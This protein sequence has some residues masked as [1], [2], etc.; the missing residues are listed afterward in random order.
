MENNTAN[1][2]MLELA[3]E[4]AKDVYA[5]AGKPIAKPAGELLGLV[6]RAIRAALEPVEKWVLQREY[7]IAETKLLLEKKLANVQPELIEAPE[8]HIA[9]P[10]LQY[11]SYCMDNDELR[12]MYA[13]LL[14]NSMNKIVKRGVHPAFIEIIRQLT[15]DEAR[16][17]RYLYAINYAPIIG[18][19]AYKEEGKSVLAI[20]LFS[21]I[22]ELCGCE[23]AR[24]S[25][26][27]INNLTRLGLVKIRDD[28][29]LIDKSLYDPLKAHP[30][31]KSLSEHIKQKPNVSKVG[32]DE[33]YMELTA[34]GKS[35]CSIC[36]GK[37]TIVASSIVDK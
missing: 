21:N 30:M 17:L 16:V 2:K 11:I 22:A 27:Y 19:R 6:P 15:P 24:D 20:P 23:N 37:Q 28:E 10:A 32:I 1:E 7:N 25:E 31:I 33:W 36:L 9:V 34:F 8:A 13:N 5:D 14:A 35:F 29:S 18:L 3:K 4:V 26:K 12:D